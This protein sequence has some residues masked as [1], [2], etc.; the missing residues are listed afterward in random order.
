MNMA[1]SD[2]LM[3]FVSLPIFIFMNGDYF[4]LGKVE[5]NQDLFLSF[6]FVETLF[7]QVSLNI[8]AVSISLERFHAICWP[9]RHRA[10]SM[11]A[12]KIGILFTWT[13][14]FFFASILTFLVWFRA[15]KS[16]IYVWMAYAVAILL[17]ACGCN[18]G[19]WRRSLRKSRIVSSRNRLNIESLTYTLLFVYFLALVC[20]IPLVIINYLTYVFELSGSVMA[21]V[22]KYHRQLP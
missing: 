16:S 8:S 5:M 2:L 14:A 22:C 7:S 20:W 4:R 3:G 13:I 17:I 18:I 1:V 6:I 21:L 19:I 10:L 15:V 9:F 12:F 11:R